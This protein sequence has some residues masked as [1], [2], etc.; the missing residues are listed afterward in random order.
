MPTSVNLKPTQIA[1]FIALTGWAV[2]VPAQV[3]AQTFREPANRGQAERQPQGLFDQLKS[4]TKDAFGSSSK[5]TRSNN[6]QRTPSRSS[7]N[8]LMKSHRG[9]STQAATDQA[10]QPK[11]SSVPW[12]ERFVLKRQSPEPKAHRQPAPPVDVGYTY[13]RSPSAVRH[14]AVGTDAIDI[15]ME[16]QDDPRA[17]LSVG[18][19]SPEYELER[20]TLAEVVT[21][22]E[23]LGSR[24]SPDRN[25]DATAS[26]LVHVEEELPASVRASLHT[27]SYAAGSRYDGTSSGE[28]G[29]LFPG[30]EPGESE[31]RSAAAQTSDEDANAPPRVSRIPLPGR[32]VANDNAPGAA[33]QPAPTALPRSS[34]QRV[35][36]PPTSP[37]TSDQATASGR[38]P[39]AVS[40][41][42]QLV[43]TPLVESAARNIAHSRPGVPT[44]AT[45]RDEST[46]SKATAP[47]QVSTKQTSP[48]TSPSTPTMP[49]RVNSGTVSS[50]NT[51]SAPLLSNNGSGNNGS[52]NN[53]SGNNRAA[54]SATSAIP[55]LPLPGSLPSSA[56]A[57]TQATTQVPNNFRPSL[58]AADQSTKASSVPASASGQR[59]ATQSPKIQVG[60]Y[61]PQDV[62]LGVP[63]TY[64]VRVQNTDQ[65]DMQGLILQLDVASGVEV[66]PQTP[67]SGDCDIERGQAGNTSVIWAIDHLAAGRGA[68]VALL[69]TSQTKRD[70]AVGMEWTLVPID[71]RMNIGVR[72]AAL[73]LNVEGPD[74]VVYGQANTY[75]L[76]V[77]NS[78]NA[79]ARNVV[80][81]LNAEPYGTSK[82][83]I[84]NIAPGQEETV[85]VELTFNQRGNIEIGALATAAGDLKSNAGVSVR[86]R[87]PELVA[88]LSAPRVIYYGTPASY[89][90]TLKNTGDAP[91]TGVACVLDIPTGARLIAAPEGL[92]QVGQQLRWTVDSIRPEATQ[93]FAVQLDLRA[94]GQNQVRFEC[95][96]QLAA[97][98]TSSVE[99]LVQ[100]LADLKLLVSDPIAPAP[101]DSEVVY[102]L[103]LTNR[104]SKAATDVHVIAQF[105]EG[106]EPIKGEG[107]KFRIVPGQLFFEPIE[108]IGAGET[109]QLK[110]I[111]K[112]EASGM[113]R[114]RSEVRAEASDIRLV[115]EESTQF[116]EAHSRIA[117]PST[118]NEVVR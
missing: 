113:H 26:N 46:T 116:L 50:G 91:A 78:G 22:E 18:I 48:S 117:L 53:G 59:I 98:A 118:S 62:A 93:S 39:A 88:Q 68:E 42:T 115:Q 43:A 15:G 29:E 105:S 79:L 19:N 66:K 33:D 49:S 100:A 28:E 41:P 37:S 81:Q 72:A 8:P 54:K 114:F 101:V 63:T 7:L 51:N 95:T 85:E 82:S 64:Q 89:E 47:N 58:P 38:S 77:R 21:P 27:E 9:S 10:S 75:R 4:I 16:S 34:V 112:A 1:C 55:S 40:V 23:L 104:G 56:T 60:L 31:V 111:A 103:E 35:E 25:D 12:L 32:E 97:G 108:S 107:Q 99:T 83:E 80:L 5:P 36:S 44:V 65:V 102:E 90:V 13:T 73:E 24:R 84:A 20:E 71:K 14:G 74:D 94:E 52:G 6:L 92:S 109:V 110:V 87:K 86:V 69:L 17:T 61:G 30:A 67:T 70:I 76:R 2:I 11:R 57:S 96:D 3:M 106:I 45:K